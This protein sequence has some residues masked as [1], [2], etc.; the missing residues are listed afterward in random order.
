MVAA[1]DEE[2]MSQAKRR[3][4]KW[5]PHHRGASKLEETRMDKK[6]WQQKLS[7]IR[8]FSSKIDTK[9]CSYYSTNHQ[10]SKHCTQ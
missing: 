9:V 10:F 3:G 6:V 1:N 2:T 5:S 8:I 7:Y 4:Y